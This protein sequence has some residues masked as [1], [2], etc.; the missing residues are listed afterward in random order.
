MPGGISHH[1]QPAESAPAVNDSSMIRPHEIA[2]G[3]PRPRIASV[4][5]DRIASATIST[6]FANNTG[7]TFG[8]TCRVMRCQCP[9]PS[10]RERSM[11]GRSFTLR[12]CARTRRA[13]L[14][15]DVMAITRITLN[16]VGPRTDA[17]AIASAIHGS[18]RNQFVNAFSAAS[19]FV[20]PK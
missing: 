2:L 18:T 14:A 17:S 1:H 13:V 6:A 3:S 4:V 5:S 10:A 20:P 16:S 8:R 11:Y 15:H 9:A 12:A 19:I 7:N